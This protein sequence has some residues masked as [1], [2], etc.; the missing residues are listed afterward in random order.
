LEE[1]LSAKPVPYI[2]KQESFGKVSD[3]VT[4]KSHIANGCDLD[5]E[6][7]QTIDLDLEKL[8]TIDLEKLQKDCLISK[9]LDILNELESPVSPVSSI[10]HL[11]KE[12]LS[13]EN[14]ESEYKYLCKAFGDNESHNQLLRIFFEDKQNWNQW[15]KYDCYRLKY[16]PTRAL[17]EHYRVSDNIGH[18]DIQNIEVQLKMNAAL[19]T[20]FD[21]ERAQNGTYEGKM[22]AYEP[23]NDTARAKTYAAIEKIVPA[24]GK[25]GRGREWFQRIQGLQ[26]WFEKQDMQTDFY[27][28][29]TTQRNNRTGKEYMWVLD[30]MD[31]KEYADMMQTRNTYSTDER[32]H[33]FDSLR[34]K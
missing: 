4:L 7:L 30:E 14:S 1:L 29:K 15:K 22:V 33:K 28:V 27:K 26:K 11:F 23:L 18:A 2:S 6:K 9:F 24:L 31:G 32:S 3:I 16:K 20:V 21:W 34:K 17:E 13:L 12:F 10:E 19:D 8:Q 5:L 25:A